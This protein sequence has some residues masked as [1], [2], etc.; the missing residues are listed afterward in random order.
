MFRYGK[1]NGYLTIALAVLAIIPVAI[2]FFIIPEM[3]D[4][5]PMAFGA[6]GDPTRFASRYQL[7]LVPGVAVALGVASYLVARRQAERENA[8]EIASQ[9]VYFRHVRSGVLTE[10]LLLACSIYLFVTAYTG[11]GFTLPF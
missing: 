2:A 9:I 4:S 10:L 5:V 1:R 11:T 8:S 6:D 7:F 3:P